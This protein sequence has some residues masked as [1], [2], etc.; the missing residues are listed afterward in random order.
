MSQ[1]GMGVLINT[2]CGDE[3]TIELFQKMKGNKIKNVFLRD[4]VL[5]FEFEG[6][7]VGIKDS[8]QSCCETRYMVC[9]DGD[10]SYYIGTTFMN[11]ELKPVR[12]DQVDYNIHETQFVDITTSNGVFQVCT[13]NI[14]NGYY[15]G[16]SIELIEL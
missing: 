6:F 16:F 15:G 12:D 9:D 8:G 5:N 3:K 4:N 2:L 7:K 10:L 1:L 13:H 14:H 11:I